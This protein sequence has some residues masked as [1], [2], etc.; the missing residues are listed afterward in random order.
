MN[1]GDWQAGFLLIMLGMLSAVFSAM[2]TA[3][4]SLRNFQLQELAQQD[5]RLKKPL[6]RVLDQ[7]RETLNLI[8]LG[9]VLVNVPLVVVGVFFLA[10]SSLAI[11]LWLASLCLFGLIVGLCDLLPKL[12]ATR[13]PQAVARATSGVLALLAPLLHKVAVSLEKASDF[14]AHLLIPPGLRAGR[15]LNEAEL[16]ALVTLSREAGSLMSVEGEII[17]EIMKLSDKSAKDVMT[18]RTDVFAMPD[19]WDNDRAIIELKQRRYRRVPVYGE[20]PDE[21]LGFLNVKRF[22]ANPETHFTL[23]L[24]PPSYIPES[25]PALALL[26]SFLRH[27]QGIAA[28]VDEFGGIA[29]VVTLADMTEEIFSDAVPRGDRQLYIEETGD[30]GLLAS[31]SARLEDL[32]ELGLPDWSRDGVDT[33]GGWLFHHLGQLPKPGARIEHDG[34]VLIIRRTSRKRVKDLMIRIPNRLEPEETE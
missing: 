7:P 18:P 28:V 31:G 5:P 20:T 26:Q 23:Q 6:R 12:V 27:P 34:V 17:L 29:G 25:M 2:E 9:G 32:I 10:Q 24:D 3:L 1:A 22:L 13:H 8:L 33:I 15:N 30:G 19:E 21:M 14:I 4:F 16:Q 11:P